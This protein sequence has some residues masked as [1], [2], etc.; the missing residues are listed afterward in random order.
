MMCAARDDDLARPAGDAVATAPGALFSGDPRLP[1]AL[2]GAGTSVWEWHV[3]TDV[4]SDLDEGTA[5]LGYAQAE[6]EST[7]AAW[8]ALMHP[9][10]RAGNDAAYE[11]HARGEAAT[12]EHEYR[13][14]AR[15]G[16]WRWMSERGRIVERAADGRPLRM[17]GTQTDITERKRAEGLAQEFAERLHKIARHVPGMVFQFVRTVDGS[18][19]FAYVSERCLALTGIEP[20]VLNVDATIMLRATEREDRARVRES[21]SRSMRRLRP[22]RCEF[23]LHHPDGS[24]RWLRGSATPQRGVDGAVL[25]H[26][27]IEDVSELHELEHARLARTAAEAASRAKTEFL[28]RMSH[29]LR[30]PLNAVLGF[31]QLLQI[32][33]AEPLG[34]RQRRH[35][36]LIRE[37]GEHLLRMISELLDLTRV[38]AG[39]LDIVT[40][41]FALAPLLRECVDMLQPQADAA[42]VSIVLEAPEGAGLAGSAGATLGVRADRT[43]LKQALAN[44]LSNG[45]KYNRRGGTVRLSA[46]ASRK[47]IVI[48]V[49]DDGAGIAAKDLKA[50]FQPFNRLAQHHSGIEGTGIG[51]A[52]SRALVREMGGEI[53]VRSRLGAGSTFSVTL[54]RGAPCDAAEPGGPA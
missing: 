39:R 16:S 1:Q 17:L 42:G 6:V 14:K 51:L 31:A 38:E 3:D 48:A 13:I 35:V 34:T 15:D 36:G 53:E 12:Y 9:D 20:Q 2:A 25:W 49:A 23:R 47:G 22:W 37:S 8:D 7:Q 29:E 5:M 33:A 18:G 26:G 43:R 4:L 28:S 19:R 10:D 40:T 46:K 24:L 27:Y 52:L 50:L 45:V 54:P 11:R 30:T 44:L 32:D 41:E 21:I